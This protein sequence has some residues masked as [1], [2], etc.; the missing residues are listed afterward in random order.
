MTD[1]DSPQA[2]PPKRQGWNIFRWPLHWQIIL[3]LVVGA[4]MGYITA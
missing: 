4:I 1:T 2:K 3:G